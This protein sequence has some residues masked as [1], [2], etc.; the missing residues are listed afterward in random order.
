MSL[1]RTALLSQIVLIPVDC[2][3]TFLVHSHVAS[4]PSTSQCMWLCLAM[5]LSLYILW[6]W[7]LRTRVA[8]VCSYLEV[9]D[10]YQPL[11]VPAGE[12]PYVSRAEC[13]GAV[14]IFKKRWFLDRVPGVV[15][16]VSCITFY[17]C[18][19]WTKTSSAIG[20]GKSILKQQGSYCFAHV[21]PLSLM[22]SLL[23]MMF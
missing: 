2:C 19:V 15:V 17:H 11:P 14:M 5:K 23:P 8:V 20:L 7:E 13:A 22:G 12:R 4:R 9:N 6:R 16:P 21:T 3:V 18:P 10:R 1:A